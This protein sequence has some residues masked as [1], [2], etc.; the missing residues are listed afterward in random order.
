MHEVLVLVAVKDPPADD[1]R[2]V[3]GRLPEVPELGDADLRGRRAGR[4]LACGETSRS[5]RGGRR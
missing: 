3:R 1:P 5:A 4:P 2:H